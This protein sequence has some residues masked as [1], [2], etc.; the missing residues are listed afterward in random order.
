MEWK[1]ARMVNNRKYVLEGVNIFDLEW[2]K[3]GEQVELKDVAHAA[4][5]MFD[6]CTVDLNG[7]EFKFAVC[8][9]AN[10]TFCFYLPK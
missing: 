1:L 5:K 6:V 2:K 9:I 4:R 3:T 7:K 8:E 10:N